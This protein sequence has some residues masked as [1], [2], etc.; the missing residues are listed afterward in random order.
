M[1]VMSLGNIDEVGTSVL[2]RDKN[3]ILLAQVQMTIYGN[4]LVCSLII[5]SLHY[6]VYFRKE[7][8]TTVMIFTELAR[9]QQSHYII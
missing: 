1:Q 7:V 5:P 3:V 9:I 2:T 4:Y 6:H 8:G